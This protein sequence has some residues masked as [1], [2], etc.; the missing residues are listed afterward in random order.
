VTESGQQ[1]I[2]VGYVR[3]AH[4]IHGD[5]VVRGLVADAAGRFTVDRDLTSDAASATTLR[6][7]SQRMNGVDFLLHFEGVDSREDAE[8]LVGTQFV[9]ERDQRRD[10][11]SDEWWVEDLVGCDVVDLDGQA[12]GRV[13]DV[14]VGAAQD[15][16][17]LETLDGTRAEIPFV[18]QLVPAVDMDSRRITVDLPEGLIE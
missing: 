12:I 11:D 8:A 16:L 6:I 14:A 10:L 3:R 7:V 18:G 1:R 4:G 9:I 15:R 2:P 17:V 5:V 13:S